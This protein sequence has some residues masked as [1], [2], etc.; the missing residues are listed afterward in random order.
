MY[1][2]A[3]FILAVVSAVVWACCELAKLMRAIEEVWKS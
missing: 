3:M 1:L 2:A